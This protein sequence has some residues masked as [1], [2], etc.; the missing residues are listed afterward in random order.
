[1]GGPA[2]GRLNLVCMR[3]QHKNQGDANFLKF[4]R[5]YYKRIKKNTG[6]VGVEKSDDAELLQSGE[7]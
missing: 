1:M 3:L 2:E 4:S 5:F 6:P 7:Y